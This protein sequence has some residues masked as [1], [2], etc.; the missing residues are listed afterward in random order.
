MDTSDSRAVSNAL[1]SFAGRIPQYYI[2]AL[3]K[4]LSRLSFHGQRVLEIGGSS[5]P[6]QLVL[7]TLGAASWVCVDIVGHTSGSYQQSNHA[8]HYDEIGIQ[9]LRANSRIP[10]QPYVIFDGSASAIPETF[11][12]HFDIALSINAF[13]HIA[14]LDEALERT[15][16][17]LR[18]SGVL[19]SQFGPIWSCIVGSHFWVRE[20]YNFNA[21]APLPPWAHLRM[22]REEISDHLRSAGL[23]DD[24][25][26][27]TLYQIFDSDFVNRRHYEDYEAAMAKS[28]FTDVR[29]EGLW[30]QT[31][32]PEVQVELERKYP[33]HKE[34]GAYGVCITAYKPA[35]A[36]DET[37]CRS[38]L[39]CGSGR[40]GTS[41]LAGLFDN[42][43]YAMG[44]DLFPPSPSNPKGFYENFATNDLNEQILV[45]SA[46]AHLGQEAATSFLSRFD[47]GQLWLATWPESM[48]VKGTHE[49]TRAIRK[50]TSDRPFC[51]KDPRMSITLPAWLD[52]CPDALALCIFRDPGIT[53]ASIL[54]E[55]QMAGY[56]RSL[57]ISTN[58][59]LAVWR[60]MYSR[61]VA[62]YLEGRNILFLAYEDLFDAN[63]LAR[64]SDI[65]GAR[66]NG[67]F[68]D[69]RL[70]RSEAI[71]TPTKSDL[72]LLDLLSNISHADFGLD[73]SRTEPL[74]ETY[75]AKLQNSPITLPAKWK[76]AF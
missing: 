55:C 44:E 54:R 14:A 4:A 20:G 30:H 19:F 27:Q 15:Y 48:T 38:V 9:P 68:A 18:P 73:R 72:E 53:V 57:R 22:T 65:V 50:L 71:V 28:P 35:W 63:R 10:N 56:L 24:D 47:R 17:A 2:D 62:M 37:A 58:D 33:N 25:I 39:V 13:E 3:R 23:C 69:R 32:S 64:L 49:I 42:G 60:Q 5:L 74:I 6:R 36:K 45:N 11:N 46:V 34:F 70:D 12:A 41:A 61:L 76:L 29:L 21:P 52:A 43:D 75:Y 31:P 40:S 59:A 16:K 7:D 51:L 66:L 67:A 8:A 1:D 26:S